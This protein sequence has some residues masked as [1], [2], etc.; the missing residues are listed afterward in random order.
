LLEDPEPS[1]RLGTGGAFE[2][3]NRTFRELAG[4]TTAAAKRG[5]M[6]GGRKA[7]A[8]LRGGARRLER[9][10]QPEQSGRR[11]AGG[12]REEE[13]VCEWQDKVATVSDQDVDS[14]LCSE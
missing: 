6:C 4:S 14:E 2:G 10:G 12:E 11:P 3:K 8:A 1:W 5:G 7:A 9:G 13:R